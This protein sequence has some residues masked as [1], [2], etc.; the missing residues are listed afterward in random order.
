MATHELGSLPH[1]S[2]FA[3]RCLALFRPPMEAIELLQQAL[4]Q[5]RKYHSKL[6]QA[7]CLLSLA[8]LVADESERHRLWAEGVELLQTMNA[9][10]WLE[11]HS[12]ENPPFIANLQ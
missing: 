11:G 4:S 10:A 8:G 1:L 2:L 9:L 7:A 12:L 5:A 3:R 6:Q